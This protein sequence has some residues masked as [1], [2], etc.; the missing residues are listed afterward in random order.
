M[1]NQRDI[2]VNNFNISAITKRIFPESHVALAKGAKNSDTPVVCIYID[3]GR[4]SPVM[5]DL[6]YEWLFMKISSPIYIG[7]NNV[8][9]ISI[10]Q[11]ERETWLPDGFNQFDEN[12]GV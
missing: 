12:A 1:Y 2:Y 5:V 11:T 6:A 10:Y 9:A 7:Y 3:S 8:V 4:Y